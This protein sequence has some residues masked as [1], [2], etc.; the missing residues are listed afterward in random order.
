MYGS[1][2]RK[3]RP[4]PEFFGTAYCSFPGFAFAQASSS[5]AVV[6][7]L[8]TFAGLYSSSGPDGYSTNSTPYPWAS[9]CILTAGSV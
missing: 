6:G 8:V 7:G 3:V 1:P 5:S 4:G 2:I 9:A